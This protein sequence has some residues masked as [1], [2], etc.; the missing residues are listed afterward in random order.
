MRSFKEDFEDLDE[1]ESFAASRR[2][3]GDKPQHARPTGR[4]FRKHARKG[5]WENDSWDDV[6]DY[7]DYDELDF[8]QS[9]ELRL[10][11]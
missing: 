8:E 4:R 6:Y 11:D 7:D 10:N 2:L 3:L 9:S 1:F 5:R